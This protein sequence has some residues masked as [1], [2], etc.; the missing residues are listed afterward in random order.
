[1]F[2][3]SACNGKISEFEGIFEGAQTWSAGEHSK[4]H[5]L[6]IPLLLYIAHRLYLLESFA[7]LNFYLP[8]YIQILF[9]IK[10]Y[11]IFGGHRIFQQKSFKDVTV[12]ISEETLLCPDKHVP[13]DNMFSLNIFHWS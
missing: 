11:F 3:K 8:L 4:T 12:H 10:K 13:L 9:A 7:L 2:V 5:D 1:M 6:L